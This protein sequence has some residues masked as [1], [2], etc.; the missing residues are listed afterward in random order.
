MRWWEWLLSRRAVGG[1]FRVQRTGSALRRRRP[2]DR[3]AQACYLPVTCLQCPSRRDGNTPRAPLGT[4]GRIAVG[5]G[6]SPRTQQP[7]IQNVSVQHR[8]KACRIRV[9]RRRLGSFFDRVN[10]SATG[11]FL[12]LQGSSKGQVIWA[13]PVRSKA[14]RA[15]TSASFLAVPRAGNQA[16]GVLCSA[17]PKVPIGT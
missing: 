6:G 11:D 5:E 14:E 17:V 13:D 10:G 15:W 2:V 7:A 1:I 12:G 8:P 9:T 4:K 3:P 16:V